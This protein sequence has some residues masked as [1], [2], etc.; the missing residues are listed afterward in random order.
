MTCA[1]SHD[2]LSL[3][4]RTKCHRKERERERIFTRPRGLTLDCSSCANRCRRTSA[5]VNEAY[6]EKTTGR[7]RS[8]FPRGSGRSLAFA[9]PEKLRATKPRPKFETRT[10]ES[11]PLAR[12]SARNKREFTS[13]GQSR[14]CSGRGLEPT[15]VLLHIE[16]LESASG[17]RG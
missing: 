17:A 9:A 1:Q 7:K 8:A 6:H 2:C 4:R 3:S 10:P 14:A 12:Y 5:H 13:I 15:V 11:V 16:Q